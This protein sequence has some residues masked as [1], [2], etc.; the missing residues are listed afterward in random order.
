MNDTSDLVWGLA[1][2]REALGLKTESQVK[3]MLR[4]RPSAWRRAP[5]RPQA[6]GQ[7]PR[8]DRALL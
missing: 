2:I 8:A 6:R 1:G 5:C 4:A 7:S 3:A